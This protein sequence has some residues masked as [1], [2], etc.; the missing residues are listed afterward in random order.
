MRIGILTFH[1]QQNYGGVLQCFAMKSIL[2]SL[3]HEVVVVDRWMDATHSYLYREFVWHTWK[4]WIKFAI[5]TLLGC[6]DYKPVLRTIRSIRFVK[7]LGL[8]PFHF[9]NW[10]DA[11][12]LTSHTS[13]TSL[14][15]LL[16][17]SDQ[18]WHCGDWGDPAPYLLEGAEG[19][20]PRAISYA[21]S[22]GM[23]AIPA[24]NLDLYKR[25][26]TR[27]SAVSCR[28]KEGVEICRGLSFEATHV[29]DPTLLAD[30]SCWDKLLPRASQTSQASR[31]RKLTCYFLSINIRD[32][33][34]MLEAFARANNCC[35]EV[36]ADGTWNKPFPKSLKQFVANCHNPYPHIK[37][38]FGYGPKE[39]VQAFD[40]ATWT[41]TDSFHAVMFSNIFNKNLRFIKPDSELRKVMFARI[42]EFAASCIN[43]P[44]FVD[45]VQS[46]LD[47]FA[48][49]EAIS[50]NQEE[51][52]RMRTASLDWLKKA[53]GE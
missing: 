47:S 28:E 13:Q 40:S 12:S 5:R 48:K 38:A 37:L 33:M 39:F 27:F 7:S 15:L 9:Y 30:P 53:I 34:P 8:T 6:G 4:S 46:A 21:A 52:D 16:V 43:G 23:K 25:G 3:G 45:S 2:E 36:I 29:V 19:K 35:V 17:G 31:Q 11:P 18:V 44:V 50:Y 41:L 32:A 1:S 42:E 10:S 26:L 14:D 51:I 24:D 22:F 20:V 49:G